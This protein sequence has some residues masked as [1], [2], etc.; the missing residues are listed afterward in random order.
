MMFCIL[1][2]DDPIEPAAYEFDDDEICPGAHGHG[3]LDNDCI[4]EC[5]QEFG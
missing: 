5:H 3:C 2:A 1:G 4:C